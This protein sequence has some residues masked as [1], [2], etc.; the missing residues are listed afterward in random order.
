MDNPS[1]QEIHLYNCKFCPNKPG[2]LSPS[3]G[4]DWFVL[5]LLGSTLIFVFIEKLFP[6]RP[7]QPVFR[8]EWQTDFQHFLVNH[9]LVGFVLLATNLLVHNFFAW[10]VQ[11]SVQT[12]VQ[13]LPFW[14]ALLLLMLTADLIQYG[15]HR[16]L[17]EVPWL[18]RFHAVHHSVKTMDWL[19]GSRLHIG[20]V[21]LM[22]SLVLAPIYV[23]GFSKEVVDAYIVIVGFQAVFNHANV[24]ITLGPL[25]HVLVT[26]SFH[27]WH[28]SQDDE[29]LDRN[30][31]SHFPV[32][33]TLFG[34]AV[35]SQ[36]TWPAQYGVK[37][38]YVPSG[39]WR[40][41]LFPFSSRP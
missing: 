32:I 37:G 27:H 10:A 6:L 38:D 18:W 16:A 1:P 25:R 2:H 36:K 26:P 19:A 15:V 35:R 17:H 21:L 7:A 31:A 28:H 41:L 40:Q 5:D 12:W 20:E 39:F 14:A 33:D 30:Y 34:T 4:L 11:G 22:R 13:S 24:N 23:L 3:I 8:L 29:A 9:L